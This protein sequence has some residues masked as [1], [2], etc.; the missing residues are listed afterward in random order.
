MENVYIFHISYLKVEYKEWV[1]TDRAELRNTIEPPEEF[2]E[3]LFSVLE[4]LK[5]HSYIAESQH[6]VW[7]Q[8][9]NNQDLNYWN[10]GIEAVAGKPSAWSCYNWW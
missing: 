7:K 2:V 6:K 10:S 4:K 5:K 9:L 8:A 1:S 3:K